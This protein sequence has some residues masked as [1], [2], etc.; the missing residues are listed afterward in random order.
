MNNKIFKEILA[1]D[2]SIRRAALNKM[3]GGLK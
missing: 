3:K 2:G 1:Y